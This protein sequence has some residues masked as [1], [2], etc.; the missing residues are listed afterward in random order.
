[1]IILL[2]AYST[3]LKI[4]I[5]EI[6]RL[7]YV[8]QLVLKDYIKIIKIRNVNINVLKAALQII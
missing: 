2:L 8:L 6:I 3:V 7:A 4:I 1:M 5:I